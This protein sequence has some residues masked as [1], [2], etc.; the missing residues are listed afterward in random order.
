MVRFENG[1]SITPWHP[2]KMDGSWKFPYDIHN[3]E[4]VPC[5]AVYN[6]VLDKG[7]VILVNGIECITLGHNFKGD[8]IGHEY[9]GSNSVV[10]DLRSL[11]PTNSGYVCLESGAFIRDP[12]TKLIVG[13]RK[14]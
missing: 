10:N 8:V 9:F 6:F 11:D 5:E 12:K 3:I 2:V 1:L 4:E 7:H 14:I 13:I